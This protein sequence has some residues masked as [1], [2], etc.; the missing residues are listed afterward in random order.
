[1]FVLLRST[2]IEM[3]TMPSQSHI[4]VFFPALMAAGRY[5]CPH[6][7]STTM[8]K[9]LPILLPA[10]LLLL[11]SACR[12][13]RFGPS[14]LPETRLEWGGGGGITGQEKRYLLLENGQVFAGNPARRD[15]LDALPDARRRQ[16]RLLFKAAQKAGLAN[17]DFE[18]PGNTYSF[19]G[20]SGKRVSWGAQGHPA[21]AAATDLYQR[22][23]Q[24]VKR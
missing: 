13:T 23:N 19:V 24:L 1:M 10:L 20:L 21:P 18:H 17:L 11:S 8:Q 4:W 2:K 5:I 3:G 12:P 7:I 9:H 14:N 6:K 16:A 22:L 15:S